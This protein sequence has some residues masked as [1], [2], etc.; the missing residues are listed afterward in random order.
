M[1][2]LSKPECMITVLRDRFLAP[3][4]SLTLPRNYALKL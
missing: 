2:N 1:D 3:T 4:V